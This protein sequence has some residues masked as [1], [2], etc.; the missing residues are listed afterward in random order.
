MNPETSFYLS[1]FDQIDFGRIIDHPNILIAAHFWDN[2]RY[3]AAR[4]CYKFMRAID[5]FIDDHKA[6]HRIISDKDRDKFESTVQDWLDSLKA[7]KNRD[8][9]KK[10]LIKTLNH[11]LIPMW[12]ME[13]FARSMVYDIYHDGFPTLADFLE[14]SQ[15]A[16]VAPSSV[17][18]HLCGLREE[19][20]HYSD[21][22]FDVREAATPCAIFS[23]LV[24][25]I[26][27]FQKDQNNNLSYFADDLIL[28]H[29]LTR[30][31]MK[32]IAAGGRITQGFRELMGEYYAI[33]DQYRIKTHEVIRRIA[34]LVGTRYRLSL[35]IIFNLYLMVFER[36]DLTKSNF[37]S[38]EL[39]PTSGEIRE[40]VYRTVMEFDPDSADGFPT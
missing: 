15:G 24:H 30:E 38:I 18:V 36:I 23:Y 21:P 26:R 7:G 35:H 29:G 14:Y 13:R 16:S 40:R 31:S 32:E 9:F 19:N 8:P 4:T 39:N 2:E 3:Q 20:G 25:I 33:A 11:F 27:D 28:K 1:I 22:A 17:F 6:G 37:S 10:E 5:D 12:T 34:P